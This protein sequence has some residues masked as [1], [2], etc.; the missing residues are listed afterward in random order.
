MRTGKSLIELRRCAGR[1]ESSLFAEIVRHIFTRRFSI[2]FV[3][4]QT[5]RHCLTQSTALSQPT[6]LQKEQL[7][8]YY[9]MMVSKWWGMT[10]SFVSQ[11]VPG[12]KNSLTAL[13]KVRTRR[14]SFKFEMALRGL[15]GRDANIKRQV[16]QCYKYKI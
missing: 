1:S 9:V 3:I 14:F 12:T 6:T 10:A 4:P 13:E 5:A 11:T 16:C 7:S 2:I 15:M 8:T